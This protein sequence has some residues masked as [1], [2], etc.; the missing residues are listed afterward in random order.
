MMIEILT[1]SDVVNYY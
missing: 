1:E